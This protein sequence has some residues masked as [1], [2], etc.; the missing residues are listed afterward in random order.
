MSKSMRQA[1]DQANE[2]EDIFEDFEVSDDE[3][4]AS[5]LLS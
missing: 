4:I 3:N 1:E 5:G 2:I